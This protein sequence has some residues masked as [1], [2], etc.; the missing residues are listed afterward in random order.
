[1]ELQKKETDVS[2]PTESKQ[3]KGIMLSSSIM[4][5]VSWFDWRQIGHLACKKLEGCSLVETI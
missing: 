4:W 3:Q 5:L 2:Q 1:L